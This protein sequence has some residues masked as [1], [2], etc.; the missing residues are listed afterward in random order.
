MRW[1]K[2]KQAGNHFKYPQYTYSPCNLLHAFQYPRDVSTF[3][4]HAILHSSKNNSVVRWLRSSPSRTFD[5]LRYHL[6]NDWALHFLF[7]CMSTT[8]FEHDQSSCEQQ[9]DLSTPIQVPVVLFAD[10]PSKW[11][12]HCNIQKLFHNINSEYY[13]VWN[14]C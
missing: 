1:V 6:L 11:R 5:A 7:V 14:S 13:F 12:Q 4:S 2:R 10:L 8:N 3:C 9:F